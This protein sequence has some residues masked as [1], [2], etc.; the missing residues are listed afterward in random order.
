M[1]E[2]EVERQVELVL[3]PAVERDQLVE[4]EHVG[5]ADQDPLLLEA[6]A[7]RAPAPQH[8]VD[9]GAVHGELLL[10]AALAHE[11]VV[12]L[13]RGGL[14]AQLAVVDDAVRHVDAEAGDPALE[15]EAQDVVERV[16]HLV[17]PP[18]QVGLARQEVVQVA[19]ARRLVERPRR[20]AERAQPVVGRRAVGLGIGPHVVVAVARV[21]AAQRVLEP[22][23]AV[24]G[25]VGDEVEQHA[26]AAPARL[27][28]QRVEVLERAEVGVH[29]REVGDVVAPVVVGRRHRRVEPDAVD[30]EPLEVVEP[31][32]DPAQVADPVAVRV[33]ERAR[34]DLVQD[35]VAPPR[36]SECAP[37]GHGGAA[38]ALAT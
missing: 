29:G 11:R 32:D 1:H 13:G 31:V 30:P 28:D 18:V 38:Y 10:E 3:A 26:H 22:R 15:P 19:L 2:Q 27:G 9:L 33:R 20:P 6:V 5:L 34:I 36:R 17:V 35:A 23:V 12:V 24:A 4:V 7:E 16:A 25:V 37:P 21:A 8:V 14:V